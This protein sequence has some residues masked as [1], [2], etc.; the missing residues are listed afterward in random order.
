MSAVESEG[1]EDEP[2]CDDVQEINL[3]AMKTRQSPTAIVL[4]GAENVIRIENLPTARGLWQAHNRDYN[5]HCRSLRTFTYPLQNAR[6][7][8]HVW[9]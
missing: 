5:E 3:S 9:K 2:V 6:V 4:S 7:I 8:G 1:E